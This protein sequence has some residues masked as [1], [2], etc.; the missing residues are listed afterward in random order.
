[1]KNTEIESPKR[2]SIV[3]LV[4]KKYSY[5]S[6]E[7]LVNIKNTPCLFFPLSP[8]HHHLTLKPE[9][10]YPN[11]SL[12]QKSQTHKYILDLRQFDNLDSIFY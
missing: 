8:F 2:A 1:M 12:K 11:N 4:T 5:E 3:A 7:D 10:T 6:S 9:I